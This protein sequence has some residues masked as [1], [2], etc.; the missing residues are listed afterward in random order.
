MANQ[1]CT[2][3]IFGVI[4]STVGKHP[5]EFGVVQWLRSIERGFA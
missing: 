4:Y 3:L 2:V 5:Q 1:G